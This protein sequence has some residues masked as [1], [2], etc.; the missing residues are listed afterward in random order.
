A[1]APIYRAHS[2]NQVAISGSLRRS[3]VDFLAPIAV[4]D[5]VDVG[6]TTAP[7]FYDGQLRLDWRP[8]AH[9]RVAVLGLLSS[10]ALGLVN[11]DPDGG[12]RS[13]F[14]TDTRCARA[15]GSWKH[16][17]AGFDN[18]LVGALGADRW[19][20][21]IGV[22]QNVDGTNHSAVLRDDARLRLGEHAQVRAGG[23]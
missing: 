7:R 15:S 12:L 3:T 2:S 19:H 5:N 20:A 8:T 6:F 13:A 10:D 21:E 17:R 16:E 9:D 18:R 23:V 11:R 14:S 4:P 1:A 22:D